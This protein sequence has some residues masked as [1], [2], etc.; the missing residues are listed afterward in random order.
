VVG[1]T[2]NIGQV[3]YALSKSGLFDFTKSLA[4]ETAR[5]GLT[6]NCVAPAFID[7]EMVA[8]VPEEVLKHRSVALQTVIAFIS[9]LLVSALELVPTQSP[10]AFGI[11]LVAGGIGGVLA[12]ALIQ[13][14]ASKGLLGYRQGYLRIGVAYNLVLMTV[15]VSGLL[16]AFGAVEAGLLV[17]APPVIVLGVLA[18]TNSY[19]L[20]MHV[21]P[22]EDQ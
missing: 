1:E 3:N 11:E 13:P 12:S 4:L 8:A 19:V 9:I 21:Q 18:I 5:R 10:T 17:L 16:I 15:A 22:L 7:T 14:A 6:V 2:G 20:V